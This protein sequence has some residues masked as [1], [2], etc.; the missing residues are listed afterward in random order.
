M[1]IRKTEFI[2]KYYY[3]KEVVDLDEFIVSLADSC[4]LNC[5]YCY[6]KFSK[7]PKKPVVYEN[8]EEFIKEIDEL[9][10]NSEEKIFYFHFGETTDSLLSKKHIQLLYK[11]CEVI[12]ER[13]KVY[14]KSCFIEVRTKT[15]N[16]SQ[17]TK[18]NFNFDNLKLIYTTSLSPQNIIDTF[19]KKTSTLEERISSLKQAQNIT[20]FIGIRLEPIII[21]PLVN[22]DYEGIKKSVLNTIK[23][24][25]EVLKRV[26]DVVDPKNLHSISLSTL[27]LTKKQFKVLKE[28]KSK[29]CFPEMTLCIDGK[30]R[31][32]RPIRTTIYKEL[33]NFIKYHHTNLL[34]RII[35]SF[36]FKYIWQD[37]G[38][39]I[40]T[41]PNLSIND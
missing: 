5:E 14:S 12:S 8:I 16:I 4:N 35:L 7:T 19:E 40:K 17:L 38:L 30:F 1:S 10:K 11:F 22:I 15:F 6:L 34:E 9:F 2:S 28:K 37:C 39:Q 29:L 31:Y 23:E 20:K 27:R 3:G 21:Y 33:I 25:N 36:E 18:Y 26:F 41:L 13:S 24:Y 32:S